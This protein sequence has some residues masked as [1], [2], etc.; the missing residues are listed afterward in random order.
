MISHNR[1]Q[2]NVHQSPKPGA[3]HGVN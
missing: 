3:G 1:S 2:L